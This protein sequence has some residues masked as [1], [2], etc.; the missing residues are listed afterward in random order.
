MKKKHPLLKPSPHLTPFNID[1]AHKPENT[2]SR[3]SFCT[4]LC[5]LRIELRETRKEPVTSRNSF[6]CGRDEGCCL[7][8]GEG[9]ERGEA[10]WRTG[11][12]GDG[13][14]EDGEFPGDIEAIE[15]VGW[16]GFLVQNPGQGERI[17]DKEYN[18]VLYTLFRA[19]C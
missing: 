1:D 3:T 2:A 15:V 18:I 9:L 17:T 11:E 13:A 19:R 5:K 14:C 4:H 6:E 8:C 7:D 12:G 10:R 16:V